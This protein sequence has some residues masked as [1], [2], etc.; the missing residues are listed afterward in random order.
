MSCGTLERFLKIKIIG[1]FKNSIKFFENVPQN[2]KK[3]H[4]SLVQRKIQ[5]S[6][7]ESFEKLNLINKKK[8]FDL[9]K[10]LHFELQKLKVLKNL[11][12]VMDLS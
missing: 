5:L 8:Q 6:V 4:I 9:F 2:V 7:V 1:V 11:K 10:N 12:Q 3:L